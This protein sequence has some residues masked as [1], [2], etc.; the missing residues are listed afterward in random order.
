[1]NWGP[2]AKI[3]M[4]PYTFAHIYQDQPCGLFFIV[5]LAA[6]QWYPIVESNVSKSFFN[7][8]TLFMYM[9]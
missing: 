3:R 6:A 5:M 2:Q 8:F 7:V 1:M 4:G 9:M